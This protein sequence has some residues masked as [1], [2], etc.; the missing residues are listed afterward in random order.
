MKRGLFER[1]PRGVLP[2]LHEVAR[3]LLRRPL[4]GV[5]AV[6]RRSDGAFL[7]VQRGDTGTWALPGG[8]I[9]WGESARDTLRRELLEEAGA[10]VIDGGRLLGVYTAAH[11][12]PRVHATTILIEAQVADEIRGPDNPIEI[13]AARFF[14]PA[15]IPHPLAFTQS[16]MLQRALDEGPGYWE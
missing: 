8:T 6:A 15:D 9:D 16:E 4:V 7:L 5:A 10:T 14:A 12:D 2:I 3:I 1:L 11:R 13:L